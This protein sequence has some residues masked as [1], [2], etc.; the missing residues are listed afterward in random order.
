MEF[1]D[2][3]RELQQNEAIKV[4]CRDGVEIEKGVVL[5]E[6]YMVQH[7]DEIASFLQ[8]VTAYP[9]LYLDLIQPED[10]HFSFFFY[11]RIT[12]RV[13][14]R[15]KQVFGTAPRAFSKSFLTILGLFLE[16][17]FTPGS[18]R[19]ICANAKKQAAQIAKEKITEIYQHWPLLRKE[20]IGNEINEIPGNFG[21]DY[22]TIKFRCGSQFDVVGAL[23]TTRGGRRHS[24]LIDEVRDADETAI[25]QIV[26]PLLNVSR[27]L[28]DNTVNPKEPNQQVIYIE[29]LFY[30]LQ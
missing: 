22:V 17:A 20:V 1:L 12:L 10:D 18:K 16:C 19:F 14:M 2:T 5:D 11:Q 29:F 4:G 3:H 9:D 30:V 15:F 27:R 8:Y 21:N 13:I 25:S 6:N 23:D 24:G 26:L 28:P 7:Y